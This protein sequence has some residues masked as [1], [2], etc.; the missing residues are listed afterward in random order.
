MSA[1]QTE[2]TFPNGKFSSQSGE[3]IK[4]S[5][6]PKDVPK[7][8][9]IS[10]GLNNLHYCLAFFISDHRSKLKC[11]VVV[12]LSQFLSINKICRLLPKIEIILV[13]NFN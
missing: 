7:V 8:S 11:V 10:G 2:K 5:L 9:F 4:C 12:V 1:N 3:G 6:P 13:Q